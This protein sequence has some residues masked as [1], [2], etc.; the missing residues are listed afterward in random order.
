ML[1]QEESR[2]L[3]AYKLATEKNPF[4]QL[5][6]SASMMLNGM[7]EISETEDRIPDLEGWMEMGDFVKGGFKWQKKWVVVK[8]AF[9]LWSDEQ[10]LDVDVSDSSHRK[11]FDWYFNLLSVSQ[12]K[13]VKGSKTNWQFA[14]GEN[15]DERKTQIWVW[16]ASSVHKRDSWIAGIQHR[17]D[18]LDLYHG[19][20]N[21]G[22]DKS[23]ASET[24]VSE[25]AEVID[26]KVSLKRTLKSG[27]NFIKA[28]PEFI[29]AGLKI[30]VKKVQGAAQT[31]QSKI[32][33]EEDRMQRVLKD[34]W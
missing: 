22:G 17:K 7:L 5:Q 8:G 15:C 23:P 12:I 29:K 27:G 32:K 21:D 31:V 26:S 20:I 13:P 9:I 28:G 1:T 4:G 2:K 16:K 3:N 30:P 11:K 25:E 34:D 33:K 24:S 19:Y 6:K 10:I 18:M 14:M